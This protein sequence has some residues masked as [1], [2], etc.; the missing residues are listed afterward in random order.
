MAVSPARG[1]K[2]R[3]GGLD[4]MTAFC[5]PSPPMGA[6][7]LVP[8]LVLLGLLSIVTA[9]CATAD[10]LSGTH[11]DASEECC[12][13]AHCSVVPG[14]LAGAR[15][16]AVVAPV[17]APAAS[18]PMPADRQPLAPPPEPGVRRSA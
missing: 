6:A 9:D 12:G 5:L 11:A 17:D 10:G 1:G 13:V 4:A 14:R 2:S 18:T 3:S 16:W 7:R 8:L 15:P